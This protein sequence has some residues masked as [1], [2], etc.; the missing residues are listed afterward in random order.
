MKKYDT[1]VFIGRFQPMHNAH[2]E[3]IQKAIKLTKELIII[4]GSA[5]QA[6]TFKNPWN[7]KE[8]ILMI[9]G[10]LNSIN[11]GTTRIHIESNTDTI[12]N[13]AAW[14]ARVQ[15]IVSKCRCLEGKT[16]II[17]HKKD[18]SS[19]YLDM[20]PQWE[21]EEVS[22]LGDINATS[23]R[24]TYFEDKDSKLEILNKV[25]PKVV[26]SYLIATDG[27]IYFEQ[28]C[29]ERQ[30]IE[31]YKEQYS[32]F[33]YPP[34]FVT[35]DAVV[36]CSG[37][38]LMIKRKAE[39]GKGLWALPG[40]F[41]NAYTDKSLQDA[42]IRE[43]K[44]ETTIK[45]PVPVLIGNIQSTK[46][47]DAVGRSAR[48]RTITHA[49]FIDLGFQDFPKVKGADDAEQAKWIAIGNLDSSEC[50]EDHYEIITTLLGL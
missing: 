26:L 7:E 18:E 50:F 3:I 24:E 46:V 23:I 10:V 37:H 38:V 5:R 47:F 9:Q 27:N 41:V 40:G 44:E 39:P 22:S 14:A 33:P 34:I 8:R 32:C 2:V 43:L 6:R 16:G 13:D 36:H 4:V 21:L 42:M 31:K 25:V 45:V 49:F 30:F 20:F 19:F 17:G 1:L 48:G 28:I 35:T 15:G 12:Y 11:T 29:R